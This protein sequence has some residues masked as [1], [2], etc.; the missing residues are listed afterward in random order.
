MEIPRLYLDV[1]GVLNLITDRIPSL[2][3]R[4]FRTG[5]FRITWY[6]PAIGALK[7]WLSEDRVSITWLTTWETM[8]NERIGAP[9]GLPELPVATRDDAPAGDGYGPWWKLATVQQAYDAGGPVIWVDDDIADT[10]SAARWIG[11]TDPGRL[12]AIS[13]APDAGLTK[14]ELKTIERWLAEREGSDGSG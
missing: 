6:P 10:P 7:S 9:M 4:S 5:A 11:R 2:R 14:S 12:L 1:D 8:A 3:H 13:P